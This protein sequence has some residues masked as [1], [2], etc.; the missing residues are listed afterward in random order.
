MDALVTDYRGRAVAFCSG[1]PSG[2]SVTL[3]KA[4]A[5]LTRIVHTAKIMVGFD[6]GGATR[7]CSRPL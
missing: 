5:E 7:A 6:R 2:L 1:D 3:P 4:L